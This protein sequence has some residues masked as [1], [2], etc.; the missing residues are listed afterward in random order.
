MAK[1]KVKKENKEN[2][3]SKK[4][5]SKKQ[6]SKVFH[7]EKLL[8][9]LIDRKI[10]VRLVM[11]DDEIIDCVVLNASRFML[12]VMNSKTKDIELIYKHAVDKIIVKP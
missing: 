4:E 8:A 2:K 6:D 7:A 11:R 9:E 3:E 5:E 12:T 1:E 10:Q